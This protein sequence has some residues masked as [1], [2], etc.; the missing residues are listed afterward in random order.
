MKIRG[1]NWSVK[2]RNHV[3]DP[4]DSQTKWG[5][6]NFVEGIITIDATIEKTFQEQVLF[7]ELCHASDD[8]MSEDTIEMVT[9]TIFPTLVDLKLWSSTV[10]QKILHPKNDS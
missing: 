8:S 9:R 1:R 7:H 6:T 4:L 5:Q 3:V 10:A 2:V